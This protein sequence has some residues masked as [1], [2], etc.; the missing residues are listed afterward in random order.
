MKPI[1]VLGALAL[2]APAIA[3][4]EPASLPT[5]D[6]VG[7]KWKNPVQV[8]DMG[9]LYPM[10][11]RVNGVRQGLADLACT[12]QATGKLDCKVLNEA[13]AGAQFGKA[14]LQV[15]RP[16]RVEAVDGSSPAGRTFRLSLKFGYW[17]TVPDSFQPSADLRWVNFPDLRSYTM[18]GQDRMETFKAD[19]S[20]KVKGGGALDCALKSAEPGDN[21]AW[22]KAAAKAM[23]E[24]SVEKANGT[25]AEGS[26][27][28]W[29]LQ[30]QR[31][32]WCGTGR[33]EVGYAS[34]ASE[35]QATGQNCPPALVIVAPPK[36]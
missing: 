8:E 7:L 13:P 32:N 30:A 12:A 27:F 34:G 26:S 11:A 31:Q 4:A 35:G 29:T 28:D 2:V 20:C 36:R 23:N 6:E 14:A 24:A 21:A 16:T 33:F 19:F 10:R 25:P 3:H 18:V 17:P 5:Y 15:M 1:V 22:K 9:R